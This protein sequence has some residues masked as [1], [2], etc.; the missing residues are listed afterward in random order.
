[1]PPKSNLQIAEKVLIRGAEFSLRL[2]AVNFFC[3]QVDGKR[4]HKTLQ[5]S[6]SWTGHAGR[7]SQCFNRSSTHVELEAIITLPFSQHCQSCKKA[8]MD[9]T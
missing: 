2:D 9:L 8:N 4:A 5:A 7:S 3:L 6:L 1:M